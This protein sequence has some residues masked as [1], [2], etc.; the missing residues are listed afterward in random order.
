MTTQNSVDNG[1]S[2]STGTGKFVG[3][4][5]PSITTGINDANGNTMLSFSPE[6]SAVNYLVIQNQTTTNAPSFQTAGSDNNIAMLFITKGT[7]TINLY[8]T[9]SPIASFVPASSAVNSFAFYNSTT[10]NALNIAATGTDNNIILGL[11]GKGT[12]GVE[13]QGNTAGGSAVTGYVGELLSSGYTS[14]VAITTATATQVQSLV[15][16]AGDWDVWGVLTTATGGSTTLG[17]YYVALT[18]TSASI[19][20]TSSVA[21]MGTVVVGSNGITGTNLNQPTG[22]VAISTTG[23]TIYLNAYINYAVSTLTAGGII[24]ARRRR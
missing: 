23:T 22:T 18:T 3:S 8:G 10:G 11:T 5:S 21:T 13:V 24:V 2:G 20:A 15:L 14:G 1:L 9:N 16:S 19:P 4:T 12:G 7:G 17:A 6:A